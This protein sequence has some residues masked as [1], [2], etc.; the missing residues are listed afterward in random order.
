M[1]VDALAR[2]VGDRV[3]RPGRDLVVATVAAP[4][5]SGAFCRH[6]ESEALIGDDVDPRLWSHSSPGETYDIMPA[7]AFEA[8]EP[9]PVRSEEHTSELQSRENLVCRLL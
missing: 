9:V 7:V 3:V 6:M 1:D 8:A 4:C 2:P 5:K